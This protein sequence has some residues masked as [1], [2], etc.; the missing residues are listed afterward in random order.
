[1][2]RDPKRRLG[3]R[4]VSEIMKAEWFKGVKWA[5]VRNLDPPI[6]PEGLIIGATGLLLR[7]H[8][9]PVQSFVVAPRRKF[10]GVRIH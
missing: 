4:G 2:D 9:S 5:L 7:V 6:P 10:Y 3:G 1:M 8:Y